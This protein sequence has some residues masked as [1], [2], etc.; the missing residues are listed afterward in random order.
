MTNARHA[1][2]DF[3]EFLG[4]VVMMCSAAFIG[5]ETNYCFSIKLLASEGNTG[6]LHKDAQFVLRQQMAEW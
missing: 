5:D 2:F 6:L 1:V 3:A 4:V